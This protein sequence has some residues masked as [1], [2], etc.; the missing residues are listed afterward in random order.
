MWYWGGRYIPWVARLIFFFWAGA[1]AASRL[2]GLGSTLALLTGAVVVI[3]VISAGEADR[4]RS[5]REAVLR[6][7][8]DPRQ[9]DA[10]KSDDADAMAGA[11]VALGFTRRGDCV[12]T[13]GMAI[14][15]RRMFVHR[16]Q[17]S[18]V[19]ALY[20]QC[21]LVSAEK[22][23]PVRAPEERSA[24]PTSL[25]LISYGMN[26]SVIRSRSTAPGEKPMR[27]IPREFVQDFPSAT[28]AELLSAHMRRL[29]DIESSEQTRMIEVDE[30]KAFALCDAL[31]DAWA[32]RIESFRWTPMAYRMLV[33]DFRWFR[34]LP[35]LGQAAAIAAIIVFGP[36]ML[37]FGGSAF[38]NRSYQ[39]HQVRFV[40]T[41]AGKHFDLANPPLYP[42]AQ[43]IPSDESSSNPGARPGSSTSYVA[44]APMETV[45]HWYEDRMPSDAVETMAQAGDRQYYT[46]V[47]LRGD[48]GAR[49]IISQDSPTATEIDLSVR[50]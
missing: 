10:L 38:A 19:A 3:A 35:F 32:R 47:I 22:G 15:R 20:Q 31:D 37:Y 13:K 8:A 4:F 12:S 6:R 27:P 49:V 18:I 36:G 30:W 44:P 2:F 42:G 9:F 40:A 50:Q 5:R 48:A 28:A 11:V 14:V 45:R 16:Q 29:V 39:T 24:G 21:A 7:D 43:L 41:A 34:E 26:G 25:S 1:F 46:F 23:K 17:R 33:A